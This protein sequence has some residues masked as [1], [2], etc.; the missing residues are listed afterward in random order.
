MEGV[1]LDDEKDGD[2]LTIVYKGKYKGRNKKIEGLM[3]LYY[4]DIEKLARDKLINEHDFDEVEVLDILE[5]HYFKKGMSEN[6]TGG[7]DSEGS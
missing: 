4:E 5:T 6:G 2:F 3:F 7:D 1:V